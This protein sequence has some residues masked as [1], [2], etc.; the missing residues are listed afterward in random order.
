MIAR[1][2]AQ[3]PLAEDSEVK[4]LGLIITLYIRLASDMRSG[5]LLEKGK[6][7]SVDLK[8]P[9]RFTWTPSRFDE[10]LNVYAIKHDIA[11]RGVEDL[12]R[13]TAGFD[14]DLELPIGGETSWGWTR[15]WKPYTKRYAT[16]TPCLGFGRK[17][18]GG[19]NLDITSWPTGLRKHY[20]FEEMDPF[21][22]EDMDALEGGML[23]Q[24]M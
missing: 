14:T 3:G 9:T 18:V 13:L 15:V 22:Q 23:M 10:Y 2:K 19:N 7:E 1:L 16:V 12:H 6:K 20:H 8:K 4:N 5:S 21:T 17:M 24:L 11:L